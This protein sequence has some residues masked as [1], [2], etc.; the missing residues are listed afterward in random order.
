MSAET[1]MAIGDRD[2]ALAALRAA[3]ERIS[4]RADRITE[5]RVLQT[6]FL[7]GVKGQRAHAGARPSLGVSRIQPVRD[8]APDGD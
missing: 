7:H 3:A 5:P 8:G 1:R 4:A 2:G 6:K